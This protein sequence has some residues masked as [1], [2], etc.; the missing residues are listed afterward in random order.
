M[1][2]VVN[3]EKVF[4]YQLDDLG[5]VPGSNDFPFAKR[6]RQVLGQNRSLIHISRSAGVISSRTDHSKREAHHSHLDL[7]PRPRKMRTASFEK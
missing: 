5:S 6:S 4:G 3:K 1:K 2:V 7:V